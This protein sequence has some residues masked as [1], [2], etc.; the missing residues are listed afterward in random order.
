VTRQVQALSTNKAGTDSSGDHWTEICSVQGAGK[1]YAARFRARAA[2]SDGWRGFQ[3]F[4]CAVAARIPPAELPCSLRFF[5]EARA[6]CTCRNPHVAAGGWRRSFEALRGA[7]RSLGLG[8]EPGP[9]WDPSEV[10][11]HCQNPE[12][13]GIKALS[14]ISSLS[15]HLQKHSGDCSP[16]FLR[17]CFMECLCRL[18]KCSSLLCV[19]TV[20]RSNWDRA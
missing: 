5:A 10:R 15:K 12:S 2:P 16:V 14:D 6:H 18:R 3:R 7:W 9:P 13:P 8:D 19:A 11:H 1:H 4:C 17:D 20:V